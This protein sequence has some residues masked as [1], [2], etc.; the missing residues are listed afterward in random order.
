MLAVHLP[1]RSGRSRPAGLRQ[2]RPGRLPRRCPQ[3]RI[4]DRELPGCR[5]TVQRAALRRDRRP[6]RAPSW[7]ERLLEQD[8]PDVYAIDFD[9]LESFGTYR[10][11]LAGPAPAASPPFAVAAPSALYET[12]LANA[13]SFY[14]NERDGP[15]FIPSPLRSAPAHLNDSSAHTY[16]TPKVNG[17]GAF[18]GELKSLGETI[19]ASGGW[20]DAGDYLKFVETTSYTVDLML[21]GIRD[22]PSAMGAGSSTDFTAEAR[23]GLEWL[24][25][26]WNDADGTLYYQVGIGTGNRTTAGDHDIWRLP[27]ADDDYGGESPIYRYIRHRPVFRAGPPGSPVS[28]NLAGRDAAAFGLCFQVFQSTDACWPTAACTPASTSSNSPTPTRTGVC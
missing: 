6:Q 11:V 18:K 25:R 28:P 13:L 7:G 19:D 24:L 5:R 2:S 17:Q 14:E 12:P 20:W 21:A 8:V 3:A 22:F 27:Q 15:E 23:F 1:G 26:M 4:R 10:I 9:Q 16:A